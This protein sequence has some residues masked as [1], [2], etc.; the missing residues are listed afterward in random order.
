MEEYRRDWYIRGGHVYHEIWEA[1]T[2][3]VTPWWQAYLPNSQTT[4]PV[5]PTFTC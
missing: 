5:W 1:A 2:G 3:A 4:L